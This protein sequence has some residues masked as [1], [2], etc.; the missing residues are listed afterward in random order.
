M[1]Y[2]CSTILS[3]LPLPTPFKV[4]D[5]DVGS[6]SDINGSDG[7]AKAQARTYKDLGKSSSKHNIKCSINVAAS[8]A[9]V[10]GVISISS[11]EEEEA[12][13]PLAP[14][15]PTARPLA[16]INLVSPECPESLISHEILSPPSPQTCS[17]IAA[18]IFK[19]DCTGKNLTAM[20]SACSSAET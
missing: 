2:T 4:R 9:T 18:L 17:V 14:R 6:D 3:A 11:E 8:S 20:A 15:K 16:T 1:K 5:D 12:R 19:D 10:R 13:A 7:I